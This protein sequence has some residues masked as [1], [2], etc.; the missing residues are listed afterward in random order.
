MV[1]FS[2]DSDSGRGRLF[3]LDAGNWVSAM[4]TGR[5]TQEHCKVEAKGVRSMFSAS[6]YVVMS[7]RIGR[8]MDQKSDFAVHL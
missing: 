7:A 4:P 5:Q 8:K 2:F 1:T 3:V 6:A